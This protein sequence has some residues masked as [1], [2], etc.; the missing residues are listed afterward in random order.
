MARAPGLRRAEPRRLG[1][2]LEG[3]G[4]EEGLGAAECK[5]VVRLQWLV[6]GPAVGGEA[7]DGKEVVVAAAEAA[8]VVV[9]GGSGG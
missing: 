3:C 2:G 4:L 8:V 1:C 5:L 6:G 9:G 7:V